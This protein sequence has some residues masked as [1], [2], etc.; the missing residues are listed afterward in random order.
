MSPLHLLLAEP[1]PHFIFQ[2]Y[3]RKASPESGDHREHHAKPSTRHEV[4]APRALGPSGR[5]IALIRP[6]PSR[7][8]RPIDPILV[9]VIDGLDNLIL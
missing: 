8:L 2:A 5:T 6:L 4:T 9:R 3:L 7:N 1:R